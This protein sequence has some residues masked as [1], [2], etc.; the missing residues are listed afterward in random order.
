MVA[1]VSSLMAFSCS[2]LPSH[3]PSR[4]LPLLNRRLELLVRRHV[5][6]VRVAERARLREVRRLDVIQDVFD[7]GH[8]CLGLDGDAEFLALL[9]RLVASGH[10]ARF[11]G[12]VLG[13]HLDANRHALHLPVVELPPGGVASVIVELHADARGG[14]GVDDGGGGGGD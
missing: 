8:E 1:P 9:P 14:E 3:P 6:D 12:D 10:H 11:L 2:S 13:A 4:P 5:H 7:L